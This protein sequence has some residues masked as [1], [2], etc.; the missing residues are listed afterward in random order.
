[1][2]APAADDDKEAAPVWLALLHSANAIKKSVDSRL[3]AQYGVSM[4]RFDV[5][6]ALDRAGGDGVKAGAL[7]RM[8]VVSGGATTQIAARLETDGLVSRRTS[9]QDGRVVLY[10]LTGEGRRLF[11]KMAKMHETWIWDALEDLPPSRLQQLKKLLAHVLH[12]QRRKEK[13]NVA[14]I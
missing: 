6:A 14:E 1:M 13:Q 12:A 9:P 11:R 7:T 3:K 10:A 8:L 4:S 2:T 5:L